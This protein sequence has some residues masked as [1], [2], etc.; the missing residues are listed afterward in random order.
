VFDNGYLLKSLRGLLTVSLVFTGW[1]SS[2]QQVQASDGQALFT[3]KCSGCHTVGGGVL[4]GPDLANCSK[5]TASDLS[6]AVK[7]M[8]T[9]TGP[10]SSDDVAGL[11]HF[12]QG[13]AVTQGKSETNSPG[14]GE[15][16]SPEGEKSAIIAAPVAVLPDQASVEHG[17]RLFFGEDAFAK[18]GLSCIACH[19]SEGANK[20]ADA[21]SNLGPDLSLIGKKMPYSALVSACEKAPFKI[22]RSAYEA[23]PLTHEEAQAVAAYLSGLKGDEKPAEVAS[24]SV[25]AALLAALVML[26]IAFGY[27]FRNKSARAKLSRRR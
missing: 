27:R 8:E 16:L 13:G 21:G 3:Q 20:V 11:V 2:L 5:W 17:R 14:K 23:N 6:V 26:A 24:V 22:M 25:A 18:G 7:R 4:V 15:V 10:L 1:F 19:Q 12:L 9:S